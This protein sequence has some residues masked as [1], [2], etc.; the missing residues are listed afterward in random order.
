VAIFSSTC[1]CDSLS[2]SRA[3]CRSASFLRS[4][5]IAS[6][7]SGLAPEGLR[8]PGWLPLQEPAGEGDEGEGDG[9]EEGEGEEEGEEEAVGK[10]GA[11]A[12]DLLLMTAGEP[13]GSLMSSLFWAMRFRAERFARTIKMSLFS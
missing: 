12:E 3:S 7:S 1:L 10:T 8:L 2:F 6:W 5:I 9:A 4:S 13:V 11:V